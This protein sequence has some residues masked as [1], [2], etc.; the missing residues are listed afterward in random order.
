MNN[1]QFD[2]YDRHWQPLLIDTNESDQK[3]APVL[4]DHSSKVMLSKSSTKLER[5]GVT[6]LNYQIH[7]NRYI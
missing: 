7:K 2:I 4:I 3:A 5:E 6:F 1:F